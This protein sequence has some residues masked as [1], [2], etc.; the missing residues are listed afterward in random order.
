MNKIPVL[1][2]DDN[3]LDCYL[4]EREL[5]QTSYQFSIEKQHDGKSALD[6]F[7]HYIELANQAKDINEE[8][9]PLIIFLDVNMPIMNGLE[10]LEHY[11]ALCSH[12]LLA[13]TVIMMFTSSKNPSDV[14]N[15][16]NYDFVEGYLIKGEFNTQQLESLVANTLSQRT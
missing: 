16:Q 4:L 12:S 2:I 1:I 14:E 7:N 9:P 8:F 5:M 11:Q 15:S 6:Y 13:S 3:E 10:F